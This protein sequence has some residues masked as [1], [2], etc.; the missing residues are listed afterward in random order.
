[1]RHGEWLGMGQV[2]WA[3]YQRDLLEP[4]LGQQQWGGEID[5]ERRSELTQDETENLNCPVSLK[6]LKV[7]IKTKAKQNK[8]FPEKETPGPDGLP[9][10]FYNTFMERK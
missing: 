6:E 4:G 2:M 9:D 3:H 1:M 8:N 10:K 5:L 7:L